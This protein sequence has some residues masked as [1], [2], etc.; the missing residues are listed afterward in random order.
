MCLILLDRR[1]VAVQGNEAVVRQIIMQNERFMVCEGD[2]I[3][4][5]GNIHCLDLLGLFFAVGDQRMAM[6]IDLV[7]FSSLGEKK[8]SHFFRETAFLASS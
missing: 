6:Q 2:G 3:I 8:F 1:F 4:P 5:F 7:E